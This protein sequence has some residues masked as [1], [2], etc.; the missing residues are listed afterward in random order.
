MPQ[1]NSSRRRPQWWALAFAVVVTGLSVRLC[2]VSTVAPILPFGLVLLFAVV[3]SAYVGGLWSGLLSTLLATIASI[4]LFDNLV[5]MV[6]AHVDMSPGFV[7]G[8][9]TIF[10][11]MGVIVSVLFEALHRE[12]YASA[13][14]QRELATILANINDAIITTDAKGRIQYLNQPAVALLQCELH[15]VIGQSFED[16]VNIRDAA[17]LD[18][19]PHLVE[20]V[21]D[22]AHTIHVGG[23]QLL[24]RHDGKQ[25]PIETTA[26]PVRDRH[27]GVVLVVVTLRDCSAQRQVENVLRERLALQAR[28]ERIAAAVPGSVYELL[29]HA[30]G[31]EKL[32]YASPGFKE[33]FGVDPREF[34][35]DATGFRNM[36]IDEA[37]V[38]SR[39]A[40]DAAAAQLQ[41][42][43]LEQRVMTPHRG[44]R[45]IT[46]VATPRLEAD[47]SVLWHGIFTDTTETR[48]AH[49]RIRASQLQLQA[50][51]DAGAMGIMSTN[52]A[53][54]TVELDATG[55]KLWGLDEATYPEITF[56]HVGA[57]LHPD[58]RSEDKQWWSQVANGQL[59]SRQYQVLT[60]DGS[61]RWLACQG[62]LYRDESTGELLSAG[63]VMDITQDRIMEQQRLRSQKL[64]ALGVLAGGIAHDFN[65]LLLA[66]SGNANL[67]LADLSARDP[68]RTSV[69]EIQKAATRASELV[70][71]ILNFSSASEFLHADRITAIKPVLEDVSA[72]AR[73]LLPASVS[74]QV[75]VAEN[76]PAVAAESGQVRQVVMN[77]L[78]NAV[79]ACIAAGGGSIE[80]TATVVTSAGFVLQSVPELKPG[81]YVCVSVADDGDGIDAEILQR[82]FDPFFTTK[83]GGSGNGL[84]LAMVHGIMKSIDGAVT[85]ADNAGRGATFSLY[86]PAT[87]KNHTTITA[88]VVDEQA[89]TAATPA[90]KNSAVHILYVDD[91][92]ALIF[93]MSRTLERM[94]HQVTACESPD[95]ALRIFSENPDDFDLV[96]SDMTMPGMTGL[97]LAERMLAIRPQMPFIITSGFIDANDVE[98]AQRVGV[99]QMIMKPN[100]VEELSLVVANVLRDQQIGAADGR[101]EAT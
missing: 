64:E 10:A 36:T 85:V 20:Q 54:A 66:I 9:A 6:A 33:I 46:T 60:K 45:W 48:R 17:E 50:A 49:E 30:D 19:T 53:T 3:L 38:E 69:D 2:F 40:A 7:V 43:E 44:V 100:T 101:N 86:F 98:R 65:N 15:S 37:K 27:G 88:S 1:G 8:F 99:N 70:R 75:T 80:L 72:E 96:V 78:T 95:E 56:Q 57:V 90:I 73:A 18:R 32:L 59:V 14:K 67:L 87:D 52:F 55:R 5:R 83:T 68:A 25:I 93:L 58:F 22:T 42:L 12:R 16:V 4:F 26:A 41:A 92:E 62:R 63:V 29:T 89:A 71:R 76:L 24:V 31:S 77:V 82:I 79:E 39:Q 74:L 61:E 34:A 21:R 91:E 28:V 51:L 23:P 47:G 81:R 13:G 35:E 94:G 97:E 11:T 84:G